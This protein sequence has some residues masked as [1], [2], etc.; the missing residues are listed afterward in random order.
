MSVFVANPCLSCGGGVVNLDIKYVSRL[1]FLPH[2]KFLNCLRFHI[3]G[4]FFLPLWG[5]IGF[6]ILVNMTLNIDIGSGRTGI[7]TLTHEQ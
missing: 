3:L 4:L 1:M 7:L 2:I 5:K 6:G